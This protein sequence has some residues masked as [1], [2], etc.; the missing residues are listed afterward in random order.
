MFCLHRRSSRKVVV[1]LKSTSQD[2]LD[3]D[4]RLQALG[5]FCMRVA[6]QGGSGWEMGPEVGAGSSDLT[7][8]R[9][10][11]PPDSGPLPGAP[12]RE[13]PIWS[14]APRIACPKV[15]RAVLNIAKFR[16]RAASSAMPGEAPSQGEGSTASARPP[17]EAT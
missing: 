9:R 5:R 2:R 3:V 11:I 1:R 6:K 12:S 14:H 7:F 17:A 15:R 13:R 10:P 16:R 4:G 8:V